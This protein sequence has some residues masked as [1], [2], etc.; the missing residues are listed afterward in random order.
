MCYHKL[1]WSVRKA[2]GTV[3]IL[4][5][6]LYGLVTGITEFL[7]VSARAHQALLRY[8][9]GAETRDPLRDL[10]VHIAIL[11]AII[12]SCRETLIRL[13][14]A[15]TLYT[16]NRRRHQ[17]PADSSYFDLRLLKTAIVPLVL[18]LVLR[19]A[20]VALDGK[21]LALMF[22]LALNATI[23]LLAEHTRHGNRTAKTMTGL[24][25]IAIGLAGSL[26]VL[27]GISRT[28][29]IVSYGT[30]RGTDGKSVA[31][32]AIL[33]SVPAMLFA[34]IF[35]VFGLVSYGTG[36]I[37]F[38]TFA[39]MFLSALAAFCGGFVGIKTLN[40]AVSQSRFSGFAY[41]TVGLVVFTFILYM[42][43]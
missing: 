12:V 21:L 32:W 11:A 43:T 16:A 27:P 23:L 19:F 36:A 7:P 41:Y 14:K 1:N 6:I 4:E 29:A 26:S 42:I 17:R 8:L 31:S 22:F 25:G 20:T 18:G 13:Q 28:A 30:L 39:G 35:D 33:L 9:F 24:D 37:T 38:A 5:S 34:I 2:G 40:A 3:S 15:Q 10:L